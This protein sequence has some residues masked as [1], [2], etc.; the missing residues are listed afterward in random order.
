MNFIECCFI[1]TLA[2]TTGLSSAAEY[3]QLL[4]PY[5]AIVVF[6]FDNFKPHELR[7]EGVPNSYD[8][9]QYP[10]IG[11][12]NSPNGF[13][14]ATGWGQAFYSEASSS[15]SISVF[16][17]R[18]FQTLLCVT[19]GNGMN[20][21][22]QQE[23][24]IEGA[25]FRADF[26]GNASQAPIVF[27]ITDFQ[28]EVGFN[29]GSAFHFW[30]KSGR[31]DLPSQRICGVL[32]YYEA[33]QISGLANSILVGVGGDYWSTKSSVWNN[34]QTNKDIAIGRLRVLTNQWRWI[35]MTTASAEALS[36]LKTQGFSNE[37]SHTQL[38]K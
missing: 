15:D 7:P 9:A 12:G 3:K 18:N 33:K 14:A 2:L 5:E 34:Y 17:I 8:W 28:I 20:W 32:V 38:G 1:I 27:R 11:A 25:Q 21:S 24:P 29:R 13:T 35:G 10:R 37:A 26:S 4:V 36:Q 22:S 31:F 6:A 16:A 23:G 30:P 19:D